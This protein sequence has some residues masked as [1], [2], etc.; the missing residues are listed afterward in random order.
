MLFYGR[1]VALEAL[2]SR[3]QVQRLLIQQQIFKDEKIQRIITL[4]KEDDISIEEISLK[5]LSKQTHSEEHQGIAVEVQFHYGRNIDP[6]K[7]SYI[8]I[9][10]ATFEHNIGAITR[11]AECVG[12]TG[13]IIPKDISITPVTARTSAGAIFHIPIF[14]Q[15]LFNTIKLFSSNGVPIYGIERD[16]KPYFSVELTGPSLFIIGGEDKSLSKQV[17]EEC[18]EILEIPQS[19]LVN[20]LNMSVATAIVLYEQ[21]RQKLVK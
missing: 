12:L 17:R 20:S 18:T 13:V 7:G 1:N 2:K 5:Q 19:G 10:E 6:Q 9:S 11:T 15:S 16:G 21:A 14:Q 8:Y 4:A 3:H